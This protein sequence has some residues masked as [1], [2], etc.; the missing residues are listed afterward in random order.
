MAKTDKLLNK[1]I[2]FV[3]H[4][5]SFKKLR[6][7][8]WCHMNYFNSVLTTFWALNVSVVLLSMEGQKALRFHQNI[9]ICV[10]K[11]NEGLCALERHESIIDRIIFGWNVPLMLPHLTNLLT[12]GITMSQFFFS[13]F[14]YYYY[15]FDN[16]LGL[17]GEFFSHLVTL[18]FIYYLYP[19]SKSKLSLF[20]FYTCS[21]QRY[22]FID[23]VLYFLG[24]FFSHLV[25][26]DQK[27]HW[28]K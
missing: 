4:F 11:M 10:L 5:L 1:V 18:P 24:S 12:Q 23:N 14:F 9:L 28:K 17:F 6:L 20:I 8:H 7:N 2:I 27:W 3:L 22:L 16:F 15:F 19:N 26:C 25:T 13:F 21:Y